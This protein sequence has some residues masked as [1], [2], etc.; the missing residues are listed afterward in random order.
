[1][2]DV[3]RTHALKTVHDFETLDEFEEAMIAF[4]ETLPPITS[5]TAKDPH[6]FYLCRGAARWV[7]ERRAEVW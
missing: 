7:W 2:N 5:P 3:I 4:G 1:M 6:Y